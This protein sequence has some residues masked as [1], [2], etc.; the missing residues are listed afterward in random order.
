MLRA[1][2]ICRP[3]TRSQKCCRRYKNLDKLIHHANADGRLNAFYSSAAAYTDAKHGYNE[4]WPLKTD[5]FFPYADCPT[6]YWT[7]ACVHDLPAACPVW[8]EAWCNA[9]Q[10][11]TGMN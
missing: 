9:Q 2:C 3:A 8:G 4:S 10:L 1:P 5:D 11:Q 6:C 7:G